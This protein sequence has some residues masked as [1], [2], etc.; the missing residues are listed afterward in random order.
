[1]SEAKTGWCSDCLFW[2]YEE[3][4]FGECRRRSPQ[5]VGVVHKNPGPGSPNEAAWPKTYGWDWC[6]EFAANKKIAPPQ[7]P[8]DAQ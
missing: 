5:F 1:M 8:N 6:G 7:A 4:N 3:S 2:E